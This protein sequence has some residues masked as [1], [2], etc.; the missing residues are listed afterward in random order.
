MN[1]PKSLFGYT[2]ALGTFAA[3]AAMATASM[4]AFAGDVNNRG[5][6]VQSS[7]AQPE[8]TA[9]DRAACVNGTGSIAYQKG[10]TGVSRIATGTYIVFFNR[11]VTRCVK[12][13]TIG[14]CGIS[15]VESP[16]LIT[17]VRSVSSVNGVFVTTHAPGGARA[18]RSFHLLVTC[19]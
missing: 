19:E 11:D 8:S 2:L 6:P 1:V 7:G 5:T 4:P 14:L 16:G 9:G 10:A 15:G 12:T 3:A 13:A 17:T 18:N